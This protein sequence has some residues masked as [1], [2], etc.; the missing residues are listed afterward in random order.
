MTATTRLPCVAPSASRQW[1]CL[2][3]DIADEE[4]WAIAQCL[5][6]AGLCHYRQLAVDDDEAYRMQTA[7]EQLR[8]ALTDAGFAP[9]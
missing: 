9:R 2:H 5:K 1:R 7:A 3:V 8:A 4:V 6:R